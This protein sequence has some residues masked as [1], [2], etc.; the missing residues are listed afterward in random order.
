MW[1]APVQERPEIVAGKPTILYAKTAETGFQDALQRA[2]ES[3]P[4]TL[5]SS[6]H[7]VMKGDTLWSICRDRLTAS[8]LEASGPS[9]YNAVQAVAKANAL[10]NPDLIRVGQSLDLSALTP[11][12]TQAETLLPAAVAPPAVQAEAVPAELPELDTPEPVTAAIAVPPADDSLSIFN[13]VTAPSL[14]F[15]AM[16]EIPLTPEP[17]EMAPMPP[18]TDPA[19]NAI[20]SIYGNT[21]PPLVPRDAANQYTGV[22]G[23]APRVEHTRAFDVTALIQSILGPKHAAAPEPEVVEQ[24]PWTKILD[25]SGRLTSGFGMRKDPFNGRP[26]MHEGVDIAAKAG[27]SI[28]PY[29]AGTV[30]FSGWNPGH[31]KVVIVEHENG[32]ETVY[33][34]NSKN[35]VTAGQVVTAETPIGEVGSTGRSTGPHLHFEVRKNGKAVDPTPYLSGGQDSIHVAETF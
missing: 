17:D 5:A 32:L 34:H 26:E 13:P 4:S 29:Q 1:I 7:T 19:A 18:A 9:V 22:G 28:Y 3:A 11:V 23:E 25:G 14:D 35:L 30:K 2:V 20:G 6:D 24:S 27:T 16:G 31:G 33:G 21:P 8:G 10:G 12:E 15:P